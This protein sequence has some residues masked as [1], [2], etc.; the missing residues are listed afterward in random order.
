MRGGVSWDMESY[1]SD[2]PVF[3]TCVG[4]FPC[5]KATAPSCKSIPHM[6]GGVST[7]C[8]LTAYGIQ[9]SPHAWGCFLAIAVMGQSGRVFPTCVGVFPT[10]AVLAYMAFSIPHMRGGVSEGFPSSYVNNQYSPHAWGC[11]FLLVEAIIF[12][13]VFPTCVGV[14]PTESIAKD[15]EI[16]IPHMRGGVSANK[17]DSKDIIG[18]SPHA[19]GCF[20]SLVAGKHRRQ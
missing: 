19:W 20:Q 5:D 3:P 17:I 8:K 2:T 11:F 9:Y 18:Y 16:S 1:T 15:L 6:R 14:F 13:M 4:V 10:N 7:N 12:P